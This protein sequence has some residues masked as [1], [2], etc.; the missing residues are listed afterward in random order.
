MAKQS[1]ESITTKWNNMKH[2]LL[3]WTSV[4][5]IFLLGWSIASIG[6]SLALIALL[7]GAASLVGSTLLCAGHAFLLYQWH[8]AAETGRDFSARHY[9]V[10]KKTVNY[11]AFIQFCY[12]SIILVLAWSASRI[13]N[14]AYYAL[15]TVNML[16]VALYLPV[17]FALNSKKNQAQHGILQAAVKNGRT[18]YRPINLFKGFF[19]GLLSWIDALVWASAVVI[20]I[21]S[22]IFQL[23]QIPSESMV[24]ELYVGTRVFTVKTLTNPEIPLSLV[25]VP[26]VAGIKR[27][28]QYVLS[29]P[30]YDFRK[31]QILK[32]FMHNFLYMISFTVIRN[33]RLDEYGNEIADPLIKRLIG[34]PGEQLMM[35]DDVVYIR[36]QNGGDFR[37]LPGD[38][39][40]AHNFS[41]NLAVNTGRLQVQSVNPTLKKIVK[42]WDEEKRTVQIDYTRQSLS[43]LDFFNGLPARWRAAGLEPNRLP[44]AARSEQGFKLSSNANLNENSLAG[45]IYWALTDHSQFMSELEKFLTA[46]R[47]ANGPANAWEESGLNAN[48]LFKLKFLVALKVYAENLT[49]TATS[50][51]QDSLRELNAYTQT[52]IQHYFDWRNFAPFPATGGLAEGEYFFMG[53]NRYNS[54]DLRHWNPNRYQNKPLYA[55]DVYS[56][57]YSSIQ[58]LFSLKKDRIRGKALFSLF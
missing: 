53:D 45:F 4:R 11:S 42:A 9:Y 50:G 55:K 31:E 47:A 25:R 56:I 7:P 19:P 51:W 35:V 12:H 6:F 33:Q 48:L 52:Y 26:L 3:S 21:N 49:G 58:E 46:W 34:L 1:T 10:A 43:Y 15:Y 29:N 22:L 32:D 18:K 13:G 37:K 41:T 17:F 28:D 40:H 44:R 23:Y 14:P 20:F 38:E 24:P 30:R 5:A 16:I 2:W 57:Q 39:A 27:Y 54:I 36:S 8:K